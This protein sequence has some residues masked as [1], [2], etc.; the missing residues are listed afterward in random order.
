MDEKADEACCQSYDIGYERG[1]E[2]INKTPNSY[3]KQDNEAIEVDKLVCSLIVE[4]G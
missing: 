3:G 1:C 4:E 2:I